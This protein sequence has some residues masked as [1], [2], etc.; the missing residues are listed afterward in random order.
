MKL[1]STH[2]RFFSSIFTMAIV[3]CLG[4]LLQSCHSTKKCAAYPNRVT[5][6]KSHKKPKRAWGNVTLA[7]KH[8]SLQLKSV[9]ATNT[10][11]TKSVKLKE[12][13]TRNKDRASRGGSRIKFNAPTFKKGSSAPRNNARPTRSMQQ[14]F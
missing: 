1:F 2:N 13:K 14:K 8:K 12:A 11:K 9:K 4:M 7:K 3:L 10:N 6:A 5:S